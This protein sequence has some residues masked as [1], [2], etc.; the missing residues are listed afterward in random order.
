MALRALKSGLIRLRRSLELPENLVKAGAKPADVRKKMDS[1]VA[2][3]LNDP[4]CLTNPVRADE[5]SVRRIITEALG[6]G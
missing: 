1:L 6:H 2:A 3:A 4:C 5:T